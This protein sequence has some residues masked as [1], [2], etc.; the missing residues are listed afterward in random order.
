MN[1]F[2]A[3]TQPVPG[4]FRAMVRFA[5]D[6]KPKPI[7]EGEE[8]PKIY[9]TELEATKDALAHVLRYFNGVGNHEFRRAG[10]TLIAH[11]SADAIFNLKPF[12]KQRGKTRLTE[13]VRRAKP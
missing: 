11:P 4:G 10:D 6:G 8:R 9:A 7:M 12:I 5:R 13:V 1:E 2:S 3:Y